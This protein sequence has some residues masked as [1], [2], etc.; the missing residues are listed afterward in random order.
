MLHEDRLIC[1]DVRNPLE[2]IF[3]PFLILHNVFD[4]SLCMLKIPYYN[5]NLWLKLGHSISI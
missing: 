2:F 3:K 4:Y 1:V 5:N